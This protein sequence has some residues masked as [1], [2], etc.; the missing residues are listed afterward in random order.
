MDELFKVV[1]SIFI[2]ATKKNLNLKAFHLHQYKSIG[3]IFDY[4]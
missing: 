2:V 1:P 4:L 3:R